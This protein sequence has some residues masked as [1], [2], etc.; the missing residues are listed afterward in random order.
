MWGRPEGKRPRRRPWRIWD[1]DINM[2]LQ[3]VGW[4]NMVWIDDSGGQVTGSCE[5]GNEPLD[6]INF[7]DFLD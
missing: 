4:G 7:R 3:K 6:P 1:G 2:D 5:G